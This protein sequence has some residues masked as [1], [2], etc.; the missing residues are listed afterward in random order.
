MGRKGKAITNGQMR[1]I[2]VLSRERGMENDLLHEYIYALKKKDSMTKLTLSEG[3]RVIESLEE[4]TAESKGDDKASYKQMQ[5]IFGLMKELGWITET[6]EADT[7]RLDRFLQSPKAGINLGS[8]K[9]LTRG[10]ASNLIEA[11]KSMLERNAAE[12]GACS[13]ERGDV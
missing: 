5:Y 13:L 4:K 6:G 11:L 12:C 3:I 10:K 8:Y 9:W 7:D 1:K 2:Y